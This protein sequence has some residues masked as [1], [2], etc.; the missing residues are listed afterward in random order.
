MENSEFEG[1]KN[2]TP[3]LRQG[4]SNIPRGQYKFKESVKPIEEKNEAEKMPAPINVDFDNKKYV[5]GERKRNIAIKILA[6]TWLPLGILALVLFLDGSSGGALL[7]SILTAI[8]LI[9]L[10]ILDLS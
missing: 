10:F 1:E 5:D 9:A 3:F 4:K 7:C 8:D 2:N 6:W